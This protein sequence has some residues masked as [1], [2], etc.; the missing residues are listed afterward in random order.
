MPCLPGVPYHFP[1]LYSVLMNRY[2]LKIPL[3]ELC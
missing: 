3:V 1:M 2:I